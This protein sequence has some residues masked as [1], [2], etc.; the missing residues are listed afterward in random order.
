MYC[1]HCN[2]IFKEWNVF[3]SCDDHKS[4]EGRDF[5]GVFIQLD[6]LND[7]EA[8]QLVKDVD[9]TLGW[10]NSQSGRR[11][12][13]YGP[14]TNFRKKKIK[15]GQF[16]G[17]PSETKFLRHK[18]NEV[19]I[20]KDFM[21]IEE[22]YLEYDE[23][24]GSHI[25]PHID[26]CWIW[27]ERILT[28]NCLGDS[29]LSFIKHQPLYPQQYNIDLVDEYKNDLLCPLE[30]IID[31]KIL[32]RIPMPVKSLMILYGPPRYQYEHFVL[33]EDIKGRRVAIAYREFTIPYLEH[34]TRK[35]ES[36]EFIKICNQ[37][38]AM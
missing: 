28:V 7:E 5:T 2:K 38:D 31:D 27:G 10:D 8:D 21:T 37:T 4:L 25:D 35:L 16:Q 13:N 24:R 30:S 34:G 33:R 6:F 17:F 11:K 18:L 36:E 3:N 14:K 22:C 15:V 32:V 12:K 9:E 23:E 26:D 29:V 20:L 19:P 1:V